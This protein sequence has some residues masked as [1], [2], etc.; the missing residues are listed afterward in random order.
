MLILKT[1]AI[2]PRA[3]KAHSMMKPLAFVCCENM[4]LGTQLVDRLQQLGYRVEVLAD[5]GQLSSQ[6]RAAKPFVIVSDLVYRGMDLVPVFKSLRHGKET[7]HIPIIGMTTSPNQQ[8]HADAVA[9]GASVVAMESGI[10]AQLPQL[11]EMALAVD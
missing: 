8:L 6:T 11:L 5:P 4:V 7:E 1:F 2:C 9:A 10:L 3:P